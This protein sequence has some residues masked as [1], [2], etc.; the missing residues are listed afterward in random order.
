MKPQRK[1]AARDL[2]LCHYEGC[3]Q[4]AISCGVRN[5]SELLRRPAPHNDIVS[6]LGD[7]E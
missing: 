1:L 7:N 4:E 2:R 5:V 6:R 3:S